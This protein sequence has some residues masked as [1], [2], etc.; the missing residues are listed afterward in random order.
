MKIIR[1]ILGLTILLLGQTIAYC[2]NAFAGSANSRQ[3]ILPLND[4]SAFNNAGKNWVVTSEFSSDYSRPWNLK[5]LSFG[6]GMVINDLTDK[7]HSHLVTKREFGD[8]EVEVDFMMDKGSNSGVYLQGRY[9]VQLFDSWLNPDPS[10]S[11]CGGIYQ[12]WGESRTVKGYEGMAPLANASRAPGLWQ[13][14]RIRF[15]APRFDADGNK[16]ANARFEEVYLNGV[17]VQQQV[18][19][20]GPTRSSLFDDEN[21]FGPLVFQGDHGKVAF[22][23]IRYR[24]LGQAT[25]S[26]GDASSG[27]IVVK[28]DDKPYLLRSF[29]MFGDKKLDYIISMGAPQGLNYAY[30]LREGAWL[31]VWRGGFMDATDMWHSRG[32]SQLA[33]PLG[34]V[35]RFSDAPAVTN[36]SDTDAK[37]PESLA[38]DD[39]QNEGYLLD[40][41]GI[42]TFKYTTEGTKITDKIV[43]LPDG[44]GFK[45]TLTVEN[46]TDNLYCRAVSASKIEQIDKELFRVDGTYYIKVDRH[47]DPLIRKN[48][49][50][51]EMLFSLNN[52]KS[53]LTYSI[54]W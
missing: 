46:P 1:I 44:K 29:M 3:T 7:H 17:L 15:Q 38:F 18:E 33:R 45:R 51:Q 42:P 37:W 36:L 52:L 35:V 39:L 6:T 40:R 28:P 30:D 22:R 24:P 50:G 26:K 5:K 10:F 53:P 13:H 20:S 4:L 11:D 47:L 16:T 2:Q 34:S 41:E 54:I 12:R 21:P 23:N 32:E 19:V 31:Q 48:G 49:Q 43:P 8:V 25:D 27:A 14:L 9:E